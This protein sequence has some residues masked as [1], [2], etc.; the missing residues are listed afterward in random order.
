M[1]ESYKDWEPPNL[2][3]WLAKINIENGLDFLI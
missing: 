3:I 2:R 1:A